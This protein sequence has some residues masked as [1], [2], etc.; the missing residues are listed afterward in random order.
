MKTKDKQNSYIP[1]QAASPSPYITYYAY[2]DTD[3][4]TILPTV[5]VYLIFSL[6]ITLLFT[7]QIVS[8][9]T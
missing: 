6:F 2:T 1:G 4:V 7:N 3:D 8:F 5:T 9:I